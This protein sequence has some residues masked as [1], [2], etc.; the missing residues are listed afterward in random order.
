VELKY[1]NERGLTMTLYQRPPI[2]LNTVG[3]VGDSQSVITTF[4]APDQDGAFYIDSALEMRNVTIEGRILAPTKDEAYRYRQQLLHV[5]VPDQKG[6]LVYRDRQISCYVE[7]AGFSESGFA[8]APAFFISLICP[9]PFFE[10]INEIIT[11]LAVWE[12]MTV[13]PLEIVSPGIKLGEWQSSQI[14]A[15]ENEGDVPSGCEIIFQANGDISNPELRNVTDSDPA[16]QP[17]VRVNV[18][19]R[20]GDELHIYTHYAGK[21]VVLYT[22]GDTV[23]AFPYIDV[24]STFLQIAPGENKLRYDATGS[25]D[26]LRVQVRYRPA[27]LGV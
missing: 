24:A 2:F 25:L 11:T 5:F 8:R 18:N 16:N 15:I 6:T 7:E 10:T 17:F 9:S 22:G 21:R 14:I 20:T 1:T 13:F 27:W 23:N 12:G 3:G 19:L 4:K 26:D